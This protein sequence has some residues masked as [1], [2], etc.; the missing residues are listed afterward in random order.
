MSQLLIEANALSKN[1]GSKKVLDQLSF[2][3]HAG[4]PVAL[5]G[6]NG[7]G[8]TTLF[9]ILCGYLTADAG[10][11][12]LLGQRPGAAALFGKVSVLPQDAL[13][14]PVFSLASQLQLYG[15]LQGMNKATADSEVKR[16]LQLVDLSDYAQAKATMLSHGMRKRVAIA[17][18]LLGQ[19]QLV[20]LDEPTAG[21][22]PVN[23]LQ[24]RQLIAGLSDQATFVI[25]SH[26]I[27]EL[28][29]LCGTV[30]YLEHGKLQQHSLGQQTAQQHAAVTGYL[31]LLLEQVDSA[32]VR[33]ELQQLK[34]VLRVEQPQKHEFAIYY[35]KTIDAAL[36]ITVLTLLRQHGW[37]YRSLS[38]GQTLEQQLFAA[39]RSVNQ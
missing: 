5:I 6:P 23:A 12:R 19:P 26:N 22:D 4:E 27:F 29:R 38:Q 20:L 9:S 14:D 2:T 13:L 25:S 39:P 32:R 17:Q 15:Q 7:A 28:E 30:L 37:H 34:G 11:I 8:K 16:V 1:F 3:V 33:D 31:N 18:A 21:L 35:D 24:I 36:D 10:E